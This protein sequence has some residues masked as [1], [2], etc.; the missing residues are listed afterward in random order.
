MI[1]FVAFFGLAAWIYLLLFH[2]GFWRAD[3]RLPN[4]FA[5]LAEWPSVVAVVPAR[6][7]AETIVAAAFSL[8]AQNYN[9]KFRIIVVD[10][11]ST[12]GTADLVRALSCTQHTL[13][14]LTAPPLP[15]G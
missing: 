2:N 8:C 3:Q 11:S 12:D 1:G 9:G 5:S 6:N 10:D 13:D 14:V 4:K 15:E 7:E